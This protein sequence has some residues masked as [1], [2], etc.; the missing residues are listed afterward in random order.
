MAHL[1]SEASTVNWLSTTSALGDLIGVDFSELSVM[2]RH[3]ACDE[4][5][6]SM[7]R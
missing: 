2:A 5:E 3:R 1:A 7:M 4:L 6:K